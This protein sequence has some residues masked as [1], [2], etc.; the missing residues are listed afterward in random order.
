MLYIPLSEIR[1]TQYKIDKKTQE[2]NS[3]I[4]EEHNDED[5]SE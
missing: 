3:Q 2:L 1:D 4:F 5:G